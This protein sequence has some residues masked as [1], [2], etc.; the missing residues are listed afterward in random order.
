MKTR[1]RKVLKAYDTKQI[2]QNS[3]Q[4]TKRNHRNRGVLE[5]SFT[6]HQRLRHS[7]GCNTSETSIAARLMTY[8]IL[9]QQYVHKM[10]DKDSTVFSKDDRDIRYDKIVQEI[11]NQELVLLQEVEPYFCTEYLKK[12]SHL[13][14]EFAFECL[15]SDVRWKNPND[16][17]FVNLQRSSEIWK[18]VN[19]NR[20]GGEGSTTGILWDTTKFEKVRKLET[21]CSPERSHYN[22]KTA[23]LVVLKVGPSSNSKVCFGVSSFHL[24]GTHKAAVNLLTDICNTIQQ[25][26]PKIPW[27]IGGD[28]NME[29]G[30][31]EGILKDALDDL[32]WTY[33]ILGKENPTCTV[34]MHDYKPYCAKRIDFLIIIHPNSSDTLRIQGEH[35]A[36]LQSPRLF[37]GNRQN[38]QAFQ[39]GLPSSTASDHYPVIAT[40]QFTFTQK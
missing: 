26:V 13:D 5:S 1:G 7:G 34:S 24:S 14:G 11:M 16:T 28:A 31:V 17:Q 8:N 33:S 4:K 25:Y 36:V 39:I 37:E 35:Y 21:I 38:Y 2:T 3:V 27:I 32:K 15:E 29:I 6:A 9:S 10:F 30:C 20:V 19:V 23:C 12:C 18:G 40:V 22:A